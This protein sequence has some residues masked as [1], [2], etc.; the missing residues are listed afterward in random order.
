MATAT[1]AEKTKSVP[2]TSR[3][4]LKKV[5]RKE[6]SIMRALRKVARMGA[7][8]GRRAK[9]AAKRL[10][11]MVKAAAVKTAQA[12][13][14][15]AKKVAEVAAP[16][17]R[18]LAKPFI[19]AGRAA[20]KAYRT[21]ADS[22]VGDI[23]R[24]AWGMIAQGW[25]RMLKPFLKQWGLLF[26]VAAWLTGVAVAP[27]A[28]AVVTGAAGLLALALSKG[29]AWLEQSDSKLARI[30]R[31]VLEAIG[32]ALRV[33]FYVASGLIAL[34]TASVALPF[35]VLFATELTL[36][37]IGWW[38]F[39]RLGGSFFEGFVQG[40]DE[41][42]VVATA[43]EAPVEPPKPMRARTRVE[44]AAAKPA[45]R[46]H[47]PVVPS[48][49]PEVV[50]LA[51]EIRP[52]GGFL[53]AKGTE[54]LWGT[55]HDKPFVNDTACSACG[56]VEGPLRAKSHRRGDD[57]EPEAWLCSA[58]Y[59][60]ECEDNALKYT[61]VSLKA[62]S[63]EVHLNDIGIDESPAMRQSKDSPEEYIWFDV[64]WWRDRDGNEHLRERALLLDGLEVARI[65]KDH[66]RGHWRSVVLG[67]VV[68]GPKV[69]PKE[70]QAV[71]QDELDRE[72][73]VVQRHEEAA[74]EIIGEAPA[75]RR[76]GKA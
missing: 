40:F 1:A 54:E 6:N 8:A 47:L 23:A 31:D 72:R 39:E 5:E 15:A 67:Q 33:T 32:Q 57:G 27:I 50:N 12:V 58:C 62:R 28:T 22:K 3:K 63:V 4:V 36:R 56:T 11:R 48:P 51:D 2:A 25:R 21:V 14:R 61:G 18:V 60:H 44:P 66:K 16:A 34:L 76:P 73:N 70:A 20:R 46:V 13:K 29:L 45:P 65:R 30:T 55:E 26:S 71:A 75:R 49:M 7:A 24:S 38:P 42:L 9:A 69:S 43:T 64:A 53:R 68:G 74:A 35:A 41:G 37:S 19:A 52:T 17:A 59:D 10:A